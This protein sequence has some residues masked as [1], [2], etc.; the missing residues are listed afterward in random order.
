MTIT[1][2]DAQLDVIGG[3]D[4]HRATHHAA[5]LTSQGLL[6]GD[7]EFPATTAGYRDLLEWMNS[8]GEVIRIGVESTALR[9]GPSALPEH[10]WRSRRGGQ[11][12]P[13]AHAPAT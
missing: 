5:A 13:R 3:V 2:T 11:P 7:K 1:N 10:S 4:T 6:L 9:S 12:A 8:F